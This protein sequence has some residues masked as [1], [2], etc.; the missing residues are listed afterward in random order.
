MIPSLADG[1]AAGDRDADNF[2][3]V[4]MGAQQAALVRELRRLQKLVDQAQKRER[5]A[6]VVD[7]RPDKKTQSDYVPQAGT[8]ASSKPSHAS[9]VHHIGSA[10]AEKAGRNRPRV[11]RATALESLPAK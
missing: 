2:A 4:P 5:F 10:P 7:L 3:E 8:P 11:R 1:N 6:R 9:C